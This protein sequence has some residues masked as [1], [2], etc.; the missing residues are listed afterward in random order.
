M[1]SSRQPRVRDA[2]A[3]LGEEQT[4]IRLA[5]DEAHARIRAATTTGLVERAW[6]ARGAVSSDDAA[7][8]AALA[9]RAGW[10]VRHPLAVAL[11]TGSLP[12]DVEELAVDVDP[13]DRSLLVPVLPRGDGDGGAAEPADVD[14]FR[15]E[16]TDPLVRPVIDELV[17]RRLIGRRTL[18]AMVGSAW[19]SVAEELIERGRLPPSAVTERL[20]SI[21][22]SDDRF[23]AAVP[24]L[25]LDGGH[26]RH[27]RAAC[28]LYYREPA[29]EYCSE[30]LCP[31]VPDA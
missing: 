24:H 22:G 29:G 18:W 2:S 14:T 3:L 19:A 16:V 21:L 30:G 12:V 26:L 13:A 4:A 27:R 20:L 8:A 11:A 23:A 15:R 10:V 6:D 17:R 5:D 28:C 9:I 31:L 7:A 25:F 1:S